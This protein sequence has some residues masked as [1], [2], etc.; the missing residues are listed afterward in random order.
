MLEVILG[1][2]EIYTVRGLREGVGI[3]KER[4]G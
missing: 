4:L 2:G 1:V 3:E